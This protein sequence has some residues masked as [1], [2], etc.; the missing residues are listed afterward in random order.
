MEPQLT[1]LDSIWDPALPDLR[2]HLPVHTPLPTMVCK[3]QSDTLLPAFH[4][5]YLSA[6]QSGLG[7]LCKLCIMMSSLNSLT[8]RGPCTGASRCWL[9]GPEHSAPAPSMVMVLLDP[10]A[11]GLLTTLPAPPATR[12][13]HTCTLASS[14]S[15]FP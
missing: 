4:N 9:P 14:P 2:P 7:R 12:L 15:V 11:N 6:L 1:L 10:A 5:R 3:G 13:H 8:Q